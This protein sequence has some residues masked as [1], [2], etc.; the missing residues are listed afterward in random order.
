LRVIQ[1]SHPIS[2]FRITNP[3]FFT[4]LQFF[5]IDIPEKCDTCLN[6]GLEKGATS[7]S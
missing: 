5:D 2:Q 3:A 7:H 6:V 4:A 1:K